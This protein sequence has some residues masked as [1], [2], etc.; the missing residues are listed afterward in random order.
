MFPR[1]LT[2]QFAIPETPERAVKACHDCGVI[3]LLLAGVQVVA[4]LTARQWLLLADVIAMSVCGLLVWWTRSRT[5]A[6]F[7]IAVGTAVFAGT[8]ANLFTPAPSLG[9]ANVVLAFTLPLA[10]IHGLQGARACHRLGVPANYRPPKK[11][12]R[13]GKRSATARATPP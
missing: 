11:R 6:G 5:A 3:F 1:W 9:G 4:A 8:L 12:R 13:R 7:A 10:A 2:K